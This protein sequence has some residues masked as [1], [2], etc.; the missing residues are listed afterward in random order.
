[1]Y[2]NKVIQ[3]LTGATAMHVKLKVLLYATS[4]I[5]LSNTMPNSIENKNQ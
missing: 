4:S 3:Q 5:T 1:M 2:G